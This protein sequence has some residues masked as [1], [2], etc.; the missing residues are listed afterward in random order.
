MNE[1]GV[2]KPIIDTDDEGFGGLSA[3]SGDREHFVTIRSKKKNKII[4]KL[5]WQSAHHQSI[6]PSIHLKL[7][8]CPRSQMEVEEEKIS[9]DVKT[10]LEYFMDVTYLL[11][12]IKKRMYEN[13]VSFSI[14]VEGTKQDWIR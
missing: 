5:S 2:F 13:N 10:D 12:L 6:N 7:V 8:F 11:H 3:K 9:T 4:S 1:K 14:R